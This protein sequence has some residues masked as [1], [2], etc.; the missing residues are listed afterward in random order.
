[1]GYLY[2]LGLQKFALCENVFINEFSHKMSAL[3][4]VVQ[5]AVG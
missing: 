2:L 4:A 1:M 3:R 5:L